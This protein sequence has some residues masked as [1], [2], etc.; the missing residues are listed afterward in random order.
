MKLAIIGTKGIPAQY[1]GFETLVEYLCTY[2]STDL[3]I[4]VFCSSKRLSTKPS[5]YKGVRLEYIN[6]DA[7]GWQSVFYDFISLIH[8]HYR[9]DKVLIL[10]CSGSIFQFLFSSE[11]HKFIV[12]IGGLDWQRSKWTKLTRKFLQVSERC[13]IKYS[14][15]IIAD[16]LGIGEYIE[17]TYGRKSNLIAYGG[18]HV[19]RVEIKEDDLFTYPFLKHPYAVAVARIQSDNNI[20]LLCHAFKEFHQM[21]LVIVGN[22]SNSEYGRLL[23]RTFKDEKGLILLDAIYDQKRLDLIRS[24]CKLY[25]HGHS[26][27]GTNPALVE[28]MNL[29]LPIVAYGSIYNRHTTENCARYFT[30]K[31][32]LKRII[33]GTS[34]DEFKHISLKMISIALRRYTWDIVSQSYLNV[35][36]SV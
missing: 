26:A 9:Y 25:V 29:A 5:E 16:N 24:N 21:P 11:K 13:A 15:H 20:E 8:A 33:E 31:D 36:R 28:A 12:N 3:E 7:N 1:G 23:K 10:G 22:W 34:D 30:N 17:K 27:G 32:D 19:E 35:I 18:D 4:T 14:G 2:L 6:L